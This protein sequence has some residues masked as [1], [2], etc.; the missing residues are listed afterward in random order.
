MKFIEKRSTSWLPEPSFL[1]LFETNSYPEGARVSSVFC[2]VVN[3]KTEV[4]FIQNQKPGRSW[5]IPGGHVEQD[6]DIVDSLKRE[7][8]EEA[9]LEIESP[10]LFAV[11][12]VHNL[13]NNPKYK[14]IQYQG[15][16]VAKLKSLSPFI[17]NEE[18]LD[19][20]FT[21][22]LNDIEWCKYYSELV[23]LFH[24]NK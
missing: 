13:G 14:G 8:M 4:C 16:Y 3:D 9:C 23:S 24:K 2:F 22:L 1:E 5:E 19:R 17:P 11:H 10:T 21:S 20:K 18:V 6:E 12:K 7:C 15:F